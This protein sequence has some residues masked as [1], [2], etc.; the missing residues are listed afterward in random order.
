LSIALQLRFW[1]LGGALVTTLP[2]IA[3]DATDASEPRFTGAITGYYYLM[4][5]Q[6]DFGVGVATLDRGR[7]HLEARYNYEVHDSASAF[8]GWKFSAGDALTF[9]FTPI[10]GGMFGVAR[11]VVPGLEA[12]V[13]WRNFDA[14]IEA[15]YVHDLNQPGSGYYYAWSEVGWKPAEWLRVGF[16]GQRTR[17]VENGRDVQRGVFAQA[18]VGAITF[19]VYAFNPQNASRYA[20]A[21]VGMRF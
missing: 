5:D 21:S 1:L 17:E 16:V 20:I 7:L 19:S 11:G 2:A 18:I 13:A 6:P 8:A 15:E 14:Y 12:S 9:E 10:I 4:Q 3:G